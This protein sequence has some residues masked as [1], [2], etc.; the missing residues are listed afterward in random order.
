MISLFSF[1]FLF[2]FFYPKPYYVPLWYALG[3]DIINLVQENPKYG[4]FKDSDNRE[5]YHIYNRLFGDNNDS[6]KY[7]LTPTK[8]SQCNL[9]LSLD[10]DTE[11]PNDRLPINAETTDSSDEPT[12]GRANSLMNISLRQGREKCNG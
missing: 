10:N 7:V 6:T 9:D 8:L 1:F 11:D 2:F 3:I 5:I 12:E 4:K